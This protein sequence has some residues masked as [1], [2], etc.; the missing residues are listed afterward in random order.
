ME[1]YK[2]WGLGFEKL[3]EGEWVLVTPFTFSGLSYFLFKTEVVWSLGKYVHD[4]T[5]VWMNKYTG[6]HGHDHQIWTAVS[7]RVQAGIRITPDHSKWIAF[8]EGT[9]QGQGFTQRRKHGIGDQKPAA[10]G[11]SFWGR[12]ARGWGYNTWMLR[13]GASWGAPSMA[14]RCDCRTPSATARRSKK[15]THQL[16][17]ALPCADLTSGRLWRQPGRFKVYLSA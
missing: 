14:G 8:A 7:V 3:R 4:L 6:A 1:R 15:E 2:F 16:P 17:P 11:S 5:H 10:A 9:I 13:K 12:G